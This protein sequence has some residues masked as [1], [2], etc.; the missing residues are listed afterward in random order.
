MRKRTKQTAPSTDRWMV[1][2]ADF[3]TLL[4]AF[5]VVLFAAANS[6]AKKAVQ[7][8]H[9]VESA[10]K[11]RAVAAEAPD[12]SVK[13]QLEEAFKEEIEKNVIHIVQDSRGVTVSLAEAGFFDSGSATV[14]ESGLLVLQRI[15]E[16][17]Q[18][19]SANLRVEGHTDNSPIHTSLFPSNWE[20]SA[21]RA[22][23][24]LEYL[25]SN[26]GIPPQRLSAA[27]YGEYRPT[28]TNDTPEGRAMNRR[29]DLVI[30]GTEAQKLEPAQVLQK[31]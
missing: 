3:I 10:F 2:Y 1:S 16:K 31:N 23:N 19:T 24:V 15:A 29:V 27:G 4:F 5:F 12:A 18:A 9:A 20:L 30:I 7:I 13:L 21:A 25:I 17:L 28:A 8:A 14:S 22:T 26:A 11:H 6:D